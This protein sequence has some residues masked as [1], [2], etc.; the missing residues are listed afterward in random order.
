MPTPV[1]PIV[2][3]LLTAATAVSYLPQDPPGYRDTVTA[4]IGEETVISQYPR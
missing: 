3:A 1:L 2:A 4:L